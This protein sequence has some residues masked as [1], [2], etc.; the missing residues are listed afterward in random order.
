[1]NTIVEGSVPKGSTLNDIK[2]A[3]VTPDIKAY[4][5]MDFADVIGLFN[6]VVYKSS[7]S[8]RNPSVT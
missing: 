8:K 3:T 5:G 2:G 7:N 1:M 6:D 4:I